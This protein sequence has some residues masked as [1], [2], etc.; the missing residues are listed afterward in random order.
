[1]GLVDPDAVF[2]AGLPGVIQ[3]IGQEVRRVDILLEVGSQLSLPSFKGHRG[4]AGGG[5]DG[6]GVELEDA[7]H[8]SGR[9]VRRWVRCCGAATTSV[10]VPLSS[11]T[12]RLH[13][14]CRLVRV[15]RDRTTHSTGGSGRTGRRC[16]RNVNIKGSL[17]T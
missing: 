3:A 5:E 15:F 2:A 14:G 10:T 16:R 7:G 9:G 6:G 1:M 8:A 17:Q 11:A 13:R 4:H 12:G